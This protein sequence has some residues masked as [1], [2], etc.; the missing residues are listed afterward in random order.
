V[1][2]DA[3]RVIQILSQKVAE[4]I[5]REAMLQSYSESLEKRNKDLEGELSGMVK[6]RG[7]EAFG[8]TDS[9]ANSIP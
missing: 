4:G 9:G 6:Q 2:V 7:Q 1:N 3:D 8:A 5:A